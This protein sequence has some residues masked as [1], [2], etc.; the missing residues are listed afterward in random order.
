M[1]CSAGDQRVGIMGHLFIMGR[2]AG[3]TLF[4]LLCIVPE[5]RRSWVACSAWDRP[6]GCG[7]GLRGIRGGDL[8]GRHVLCPGLAF[9]MAMKTEP[10]H[11]FPSGRIV[12]R[13]G[14]VALQAFQV[15][16]H[17]QRQGLPLF[18]AEAALPLNRPARIKSL[19]QR[20]I[21]GKLVMGIMAFNAPPILLRTLHPLGSV[22]SLFQFFLNLIV[23]GKALFG[24]EEIQEPF[25]D[26]P[27]VRVE[28]FSSH[29]LVTV[30]TG[31]LPVHRDVEPVPLNEPR[32][33]CLGSTREKPCNDQ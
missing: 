9:A 8:P 13:D 23:A 19:P 28:I 30:H 31:V 7:E 25:S 5:I 22:K 11:L 33:L 21:K 24:R 12:H 26:L 2:M 20:R 15:R 14:L 17:G 1:A 4:E 3:G 29:I 6:V 10:G 27:G 32:G 16:T 18:M